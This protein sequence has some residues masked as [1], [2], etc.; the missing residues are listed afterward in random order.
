VIAGVEVARRERRVITA[1]L[2]VAAAVMLV[3]SP[4]HG[5][6]SSRVWCDQFHVAYAVDTSC[7]VEQRV[8]RLYAIRCIPDKQS[9]P[10]P[11][12]TVS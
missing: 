12:P 6:A 11:A 1:L 8:S 5:A 7:V 10:R 2:A 9:A 3:S 4:A